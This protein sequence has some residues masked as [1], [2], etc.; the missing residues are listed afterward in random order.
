MSD[1]F[2]ELFDRIFDNAEAYNHRRISLGF[3][4]TVQSI[5]DDYYV[6]RAILEDQQGQLWFMDKTEVSFVVS[7]SRTKLYRLD[8]RLKLC[9]VDK[10]STEKLVILPDDDTGGTS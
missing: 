1:T 2:E 8:N 5:W 6:G 4:R 10:P 3:Y 7:G 9:G